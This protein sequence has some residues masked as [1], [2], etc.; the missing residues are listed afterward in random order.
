V[1]GDAISK[2][3]DDIYATPEEIIAEMRDIIGTK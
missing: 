2:L 1:S 3:L